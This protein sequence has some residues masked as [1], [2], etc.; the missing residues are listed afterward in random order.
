[1]ALPL[2]YSVTFERLALWLLKLK[3]EGF[4]VALILAL[5]N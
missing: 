3:R 1:M 5:I 4:A 2:P